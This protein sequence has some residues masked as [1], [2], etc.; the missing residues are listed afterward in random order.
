MTK[1]EGAIGSATL[2]AEVHK[3]AEIPEVHKEPKM[4]SGQSTTSV[5]EQME[6]VLQSPQ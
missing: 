4:T 1:V 6:L 5:Q 3:E 2:E